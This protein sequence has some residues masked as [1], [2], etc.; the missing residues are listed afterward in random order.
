MTTLSSLL[1]EIQTLSQRNPTLA[2]EHFERIPVNN[3]KK[4]TDEKTVKFL[5]RHMTK[6]IIQ[7]YTKA[8]Q[9]NGST[10]IQSRGTPKLGPRSSLGMVQSRVIAIRDKVLKH[11]GIV[12]KTPF[13]KKRLTPS[14][15]RKGGFFYG[16]EF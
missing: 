9:E 14:T 12:P 4:G 5:V 10:Q 3:L 8:A 15:V 11:Y 2:L 7:A 1:L 13:N 16:P 6:G